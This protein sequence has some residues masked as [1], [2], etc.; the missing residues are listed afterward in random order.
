MK[1]LSTLIV[2]VLLTG[3]S[4]TP[5][6]PAAERYPEVVNVA[7]GPS[8]RFISAVG[9]VTATARFKVTT[10]GA[11]VI[12]VQALSE[13]SSLTTLGGLHVQTWQFAPHR[14][15]TFETTLKVEPRR[16]TT[17]D[18]LE[19]NHW[20]TFALPIE[21][22]FLISPILTC[23]PSIS[24]PTDA[25]TVSRVTGQVRCDCNGGGVV[26]DVDVALHR[27]KGN[28]D[29]L[30]AEVYRA[31][32]SL[33]GRFDFSG[34]LPG[35]YRLS[36]D[37]KGFFRRDYRLRVVRDG[38]RAT[39]FEPRLKPNPAYVPT[40]PVFVARAPVPGYPADARQRGITGQ[41]TLRVDTGGW[42]QAVSGPPDLA[43]AA[44][45]NLRHWQFAGNP[46]APFEVFY[47]YSLV[48]GDCGPQQNPTVR[49]ELPFRVSIV[50]K[51]PATC[52]R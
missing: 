45:E 1:S 34:V 32:T 18:D 3:L 17:C 23:D 19:A 40:A 10:D 16:K 36:L 44:I 29:D 11:R 14:P 4:Q 49:M 35:E 22:T 26:S 46:S 42:R 20:G 33:T 39:T 30:D 48:E 8:D 25:I 9:A 15:T 12:G 47:D 28:D 6:S 50:A 5:Q 51:R 43:R 21:A 7:L 24:L 31:E 37:A 38:G 52:G 2:F 27:L 41:V 13:P